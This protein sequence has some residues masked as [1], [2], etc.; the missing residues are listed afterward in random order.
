M[1]AT[2]DQL[3][4]AT[5]YAAAFNRAP[6]AAGFDFWLQAYQRGATVTGLAGN[7]LGTP[8]GQTAYPPGMSS[9]AFVAA[10][11]TSVFGRP[12]DAGGLQFWSAALD[13]LGGAGS[14]AAKAA[15]MA[16]IIGIASTPLAAKPEG[17]SDEAYAQTVADR[18]RFL[19]KAE[20]G[21]YFAAE[22]RSNDLSL[23][24]LV[25][26][27]VTADPASVTAARTLAEQTIN[28]PAPPVVVP[29]L[30][31]ADDVA[32]I[33]SKLAAYAGTDATADTSGMSAAQLKAVAAGL[34]KIKADGVSGALALT[35]TVTASEAGSLLAKYAGTT[36]SAAAAGMDAAYLAVLAGAATKFAASGIATPT[37]VL[38]DN[39]LDDTATEALLAKSAGA[40]I[41]A[42]GATAPELL[43]IVN[44]IGAVA[45]GGITGTFAL[46]GSL[47]AAQLTSLL[48]KLASGAHVT[49]DV[50]AMDASQL[51]V[52]AAKPL[53]LDPGA[54]TGSLHLSAPLTGTAV[55]VLLNRYAGTDATLAATGAGSDVLNSVAA[56]VAK[57]SGISGDLVLPSN[58]I[59]G[60]G[61]SLLGKYA[62][63]TATVDASLFN[64]TQLQA[65][66]GSLDKLATVTQPK[67]V[68]AD[69]W[70]SS[71]T[72]VDNLLAKSTD[73]VVTATGISSA[74]LTSVLNNLSHVAADGI[75]GTLGI[76]S[77]SATAAGLDLLLQ[78][79]A[80]AATVNVNAASMDAD[81]VVVLFGQAAKIDSLTNLSVPA[82]TMAR[83]PADIGTLFQKGI[84]IKVDLTGASTAQLN[85]VASYVNQFADDGLTGSYSLDNSLNAAQLDILLGVRVA[86]AADVTVQSIGMTSE[87]LMSV[88]QGIAKVDTIRG[89]ALTSAL[90]SSLTDAQFEAL[91]SKAM[92]AAVYVDSLG[93][94]KT[95]KV[96]AALDHIGAG[97]LSFNLFVDATQL[98]AGTVGQLDAKLNAGATL[99]VTGTTAS[100]VIDLTGLSK[101]AYVVGGAGA[102]M[103]TLG[104]GKSTVLLGGKTDSRATSVVDTTQSTSAS[105][106]RIAGLKDGDVIKLSTG[107]NVYGAGIQ[108]TGATNV[109]HVQQIS[110]DAT[111]GP[112]TFAT[113]YN[114]LSGL[115]HIASTSA[116]ASLVVFTLTSPSGLAGKFLIVN[117]GDA[118][119]TTDDTIVELIGA[120]DQLVYTV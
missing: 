120:T 16:D 11:Y 95:A 60:Y 14:T 86:A 55:A 117:D 31:S 19:N 45:A 83:L 63:T 36:A 84:G 58:V 106:D 103:I 82:G 9:Q 98:Q 40:Q 38:A 35:G 5:L 29:A 57:V 44:H 101:Q 49:A 8:E 3:A 97:G 89:L 47:S 48:G 119:I 88:A 12:A 85:G 64:S 30:T 72:V 25:L 81:Q 46:L 96:L 13:A 39:L 68:V 87:Q 34:G 71:S 1:P 105:I 69:A 91:L 24:K 102:D 2:P 4:I 90:S 78:K 23:A 116:A 80:V 99:N 66:Y 94:A 32:A 107:A 28:P 77:T 75:L 104:S 52:L 115:V 62:G 110:Q 6:D 67:L 92:N 100:D 79:T 7:F 76:A 10:F 37:L 108:F 53:A 27:A 74:Q 22:L 61:L 59:P 114:A 21:V 20:V 54:L 65:L 112:T 26:A 18:G 42:A 50:S 15:F 118:A 73:A 51:A 111:A 17:L 56:A 41:N 33:T 43:S 70:L 109:L 113:V 93:A